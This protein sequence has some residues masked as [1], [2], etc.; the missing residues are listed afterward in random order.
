MTVEVVALDPHRAGPA[1][2][3]EY[4]RIRRTSADPADGALDHDSVVTR[5]RNPFPGLG[6][7][8]YRLVR[9]GGEA[10]GLVY[11]RYPE[12]ENRHLVLAEVVVQPD[13][14]R[15]GI[16]TA[17]LRALLPELRACGRRVIEGWLVVED[18]AG[19]RWAKSLGFR[20]VRSVTRMGLDFACADRSRWDV[21]PP[22]GYRLER[23]VG[24]A[25]ERLLAS[26]A[27]AR[28]AI[29]DAPTGQTEF[30][31]PDWT[32]ERVR[33]AEEEDRAKGVEQRVVVALRGDTVVG[34]TEV[35]RVPHRRDEYYQGD[36]AVLA[37]HRGRRIGLWL[38]GAMARWLVAERP[39]PTRVTTA[40]G[41]D[42]EHMI[43][44]NRELGFHVVNTQLVIA[45]D[46]EAL[47]R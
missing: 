2:L 36:T 31:Q 17:A 25:P 40:T 16:G 44:V 35:V 32:P 9:V 8:G 4:V 10:V 28:S 6:D 15:R 20:T 47:S 5:M 41:S 13:R 34:L 39:E 45:H 26:Y 14:R 12:D 38:K 33:A 21:A 37:A 30:R 11:L 7:A 24:A 23:W 22:A 18:S 46:V 42:N 1:D 43:R 19:D 27:E 29:H 3:A